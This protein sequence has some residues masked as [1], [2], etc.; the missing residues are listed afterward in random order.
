MG[1]TMYTLFNDPSDP[2][3]GV[4]QPSS[5]ALVRKR[6]RKNLIDAIRYARNSTYAVPSNHILVS[7]LN[8]L[9]AN[10]NVNLIEYY[11]IVTKRAQGVAKANKISSALQRGSIRPDGLFYGDNTTEIHVLMDTPINIFQLEDAWK[12]MQP[13]RV[14]RHPRTSLSINALDGSESFEEDGIAVIAIDIKL[15]AMQYYMWYK[16]QKEENPEFFQTT[17][18]FVYQYPLT[19]MLISH[20]DVA[21]SNR[22]AAIFKGNGVSPFENIWPFYMT[23]HSAN[24]D[25]YLFDRI[26]TMM[27]KARVFDEWLHYPNM[28]TAK[29]MYDVVRLPQT[30]VTRQNAWAFN[31]ARVPYLNLLLEMENECGTFRNSNIRSTLRKKVR[32]LRYDKDFKTSIEDGD[33]S[34]FLEELQTQIEDLL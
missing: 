20:H 22:M 18:Q 25:K 29:T 3:Q 1:N 10:P 9:N 28:V 31:I 12:R 32:Q 15:L 5:F 7:I 6:L 24:V 2:A 34:S 14:L 21:I 11:D 23:D 8:D 26:E 30:L 27:S 19:N 13:L 33:S 4:Q 16:E 17:R